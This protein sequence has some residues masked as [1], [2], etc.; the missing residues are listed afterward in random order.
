MDLKRC[1]SIGNKVEIVTFNKNKEKVVYF[2]K[3]V[4]IDEGNYIVLE[5]PISEGNLVP[6]QIGSLFDIYISN[7]NSFYFMK[8]EMK[9]RIKANV[10]TIIMSVVGTVSKIQRRDFFRFEC[11]LNTKVGLLNEGEENDNK[12]ARYFDSIIHDISGGGIR[13]S[14]DIEVKNGDK[15][16]C[17]IDLETDSVLV[18]GNVVRVSKGKGN[19][20]HEYGVN[21]ISISNQN[22]DQII[23]YIFEQQR[24]LRKKGMM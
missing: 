15:L 2:S 14:S 4:E 1:V 11:T 20:K 9:E 6:L 7:K 22:R 19:Y 21:F 23:K 3:L 12:N 10:S 13:I 16:E 8:A 17:I 18:I 5:A 24:K